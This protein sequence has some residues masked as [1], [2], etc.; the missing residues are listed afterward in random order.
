MDGKTPSR[1]HSSLGI[2]SCLIVPLQFV[3]GLNPDPKQ[4][5]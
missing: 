5:V 4:Q 2:G 3:P 1:V